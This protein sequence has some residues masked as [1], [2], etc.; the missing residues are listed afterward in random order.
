MSKI[1]SFLA[2]E[3]KKRRRQA[4][5]S[6]EKFS[7]MT[8]I[9]KAQ[10]SELERGIANPSLGFLEK[11]AD[12]FQVS[13]AEL[14]DADDTLKNPERLK[15]SILESLENLSPDELRRVLSLIRLAQ[16]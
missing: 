9:S 15:K 3:L 1:K 5:L 14:L 6:Q 13:V 10:I 7:E 4:G 12:C 11:I 16:R 2:G 8:G